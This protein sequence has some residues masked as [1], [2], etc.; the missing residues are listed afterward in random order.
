MVLDVSMDEF[1][2]ILVLDGCFL[3]EYLRKCRY[4]KL[5]KDD[6]PIFGVRYMGTLIRDLILLENQIP[7]FV[8]DC[9]FQ[10]TMT[11][12]LNLP[13]F[14]LVMSKFSDIFS[15]EVELTYHKEC[16]NKHIL[17][18]L[19]NS[20]IMPS[21]VPKHVPSNNYL[22][23]NLQLMSATNLEE[24]GIKLK[25]AASNTISS[26]LDIQFK[27][28]VLQIPRLLV[29]DCT[30][31]LFQNLI[32]LEQ[33]LPHCKEVISSYMALLD[34]LINTT[35]DMEIFIKSEIFVN[36]V[37]I[38][39]ATMFFNQVLNNVDVTHFYYL[40][41]VKDVNKYSR[42]SW[43]RYRRVLLHNYFNHPWA[44]ISVLAAAVLLILTLLQTIFTIIK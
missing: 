3:I 38:E 44:L 12:D 19:R 2:K 36:M 9:L 21:I 25:K 11:P 15:T 23:N 32:C 37:D 5:V 14:T 39:D 7:W 35:K 18:L 13:L 43:P 17:D 29:D 4:R 42:R 34:Y 24:A 41:V 26:I 40:D 31:P 1:V 20:L 28:G 30:E 10:K 16:E 22:I 8:L 27:N 33:C 6:D